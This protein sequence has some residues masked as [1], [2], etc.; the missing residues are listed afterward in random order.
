MAHQKNEDIRDIL[1]IKAA[2]ASIMHNPSQ[3]FNERFDEWLSI[4]TAPLLC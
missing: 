1:L 2:G 4:C 3:I